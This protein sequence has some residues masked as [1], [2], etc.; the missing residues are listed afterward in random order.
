MYYN[1]QTDLFLHSGRTW[2]WWN[3]PT[4]LTGNA[5]KQ[6]KNIAR[7]SLHYRFY[8]L[9]ESMGVHIAILVCMCASPM[10]IHIFCLGCWRSGVVS[11]RRE[12]PIRYDYS[13]LRKSS[14]YSPTQ[15]ILTRHDNGMGW[16]AMRVKF[17]NRVLIVIMVI[18]DLIML[19][20]FS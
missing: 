8:W 11:S 14:G 9:K 3:V 12:L 1:F 13:I 19:T 4:K 7:A 2:D 18:Y 20:L 17:G 10:W 5:V 16:G 15:Q 6:Y